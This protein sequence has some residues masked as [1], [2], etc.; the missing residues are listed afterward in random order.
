[1]AAAA[2]TVA[3]AAAAAALG[4]RLTRAAPLPGQGQ[5]M[6]VVPPLSHPPEMLAI[7]RP[8]VW[9]T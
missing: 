3:A 4:Q 8:D 2:G 5:A 6:W 7:R 9:F 1:M